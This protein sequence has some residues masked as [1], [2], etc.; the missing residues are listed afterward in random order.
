MREV[1]QKA[2]EAENEGKGRVAAA[3]AEA[4]AILSKAAK[5]SQEL[6]ERGQQEARTGA[7]QMVEA[8]VLQAEREK[9]ELLARAAGEI[10]AQVRLDEATRQRAV[11]S[12]VRCVCG[13]R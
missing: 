1:I 5:Q 9:G 13:F 6:L 10:E 12:V 3:K 4:E 7:E 8:V 2:I 11:D